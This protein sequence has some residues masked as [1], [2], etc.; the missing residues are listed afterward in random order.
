MIS[1]ASQSFPV[2]VVVKARS[3]QTFV[4]SERRISDLGG[5]KRTPGKFATLARMQLCKRAQISSCR[6][7][8]GFRVITAPARISWYALLICEREPPPKIG[9]YRN[10]DFLQSAQEFLQQ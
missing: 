7:P 1:A 2:A 3:G 8:G 10:F 4:S 6:V 9:R 5:N